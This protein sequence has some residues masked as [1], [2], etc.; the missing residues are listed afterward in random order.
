MFTS[1]VFGTSHENMSLIFCVLEAKIFGFSRP[2]LYLFF[3]LA[4]MSL[5]VTQSSMK[6]LI[7]CVPTLWIW[8]CGQ[9]CGKL[10]HSIVKRKFFKIPLLV[11]Y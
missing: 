2:K 10:L 8:K 3:L 5:F 1:S 7:V 6:S 4:N 11:L 9:V